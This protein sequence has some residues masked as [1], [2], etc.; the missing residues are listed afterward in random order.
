MM[1]H[2]HLP[3]S[4]R[5]LVSILFK[6]KWSMG[7]VMAVTVGVSFAYVMLVRNDVYEVTAKILVKIGH[8]QAMPST[9]LGDRP[10]M[11]IGQR[12]QDV[13]SEV[14]LLESADLLGQLVDELGLDKPGPPEAVPERFVP[15]VRYHARHLVSQVRDWKDELLIRLG[16]R[17]RLTPREEAIAM[18]QKG[19][20]V[21]PVKDSNVIVVQLYLPVRQFAAPILNKLVDLYQTFRLELLL[22]TGA[23]SFFE[24]QVSEHAATLAESE[25]RLHE[26]EIAG[27]IRAPDRQK[28]ELVEAIADAQA[29]LTAAEVHQ[30]IASAKLQRFSQELESH[31]TDFAALGDFDRESFLGSIMLQLADL[32]RQLAFLK[33]EPVANSELMRANR[34]HFAVLT[35]MIASNLRT[36]LAESEKTCAAWRGMEDELRQRLSSLHEREMEWRALR[37]SVTVVEGTYLYYEQKHEEATAT[38]A[39][40][41]EK[42]GNVEVIEHAIAPF[43]PSG[44]RKLKLLVIALGAGLLAALAWASVLEF[45]DHRVYDVDTVEARLGAPVI[46]VLP[47][48]KG[49]YRRILSKDGTV[50]AGTNRRG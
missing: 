41:R 10:M 44:I 5:D 27:N 48:T 31:E 28:A 37:R 34:E 1:K 9:V 13:N 3:T 38:A 20:R 50:L 4:T 2:L 30:E 18:L 46:A 49:R 39:M 11:I 6:R 43:A 16:F 21:T 29:A 45:F 12:Y 35:E 42:V 32:Q 23:A 15:R 36:R 24:T 22:N 26:F 19:L 8:E 47:L 40:E 25:Q 33:L 17:V 7:V 14:G